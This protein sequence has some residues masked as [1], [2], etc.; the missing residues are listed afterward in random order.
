MDLTLNEYEVLYGIVE[1]GL[2]ASSRALSTMTTGGIQLREPSMEFIPLNLVPSIAG[3]PE[4]VVAAIYLGIEGD[5]RGHL[6]ILFTSPSALLVVD[7]LMEDPPGTTRSI[8]DLGASAL[9]ET[10]NVC[11]TAFLNALADRTGLTIVPTTP[12]VVIDMAGAILQSVVSE[13]YLNGDEVLLVETSFNSDIPGAFLLMP[14][15]ESMARLVAALE[16]TG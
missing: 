8:D 6:M 10:G 1:R 7:M 15:H 11:G 16:S 12:A 13:L 3:G 9:A 5:I 4:V 14:D 2:Q